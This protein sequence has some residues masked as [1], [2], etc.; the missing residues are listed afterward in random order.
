MESFINM[1]PEVGFGLAVWRPV[2]ESHDE[3]MSKGLPF[4]RNKAKQYR[5][6]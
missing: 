4:L 5:L 3:V 1:P 6:I 2:A